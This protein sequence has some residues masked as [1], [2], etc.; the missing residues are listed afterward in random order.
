MIWRQILLLYIGVAGAAGLVWVAPELARGWYP[1]GRVIGVT[2]LFTLGWLTL[3]IWGA[4]YQFLPVALERRIRWPWL[5]HGTYGLF[6]PGLALF[7]VG[8]AFGRAGVMLAG[9]AALVVAVVGFC[10]NLWATLA[11][12][13]KRDLTWWCLLAAG[14]FLLLTL[15]VGMASAGSLRWG[16]LG[17]GRWAALGVH[18][19]V[20]LAG[21]VL[22][23]V[24]G[25]GHR[26]LP[27]FLLSHGAPEV[28]GRAAAVLVAGGTVALVALHHA[29]PVLSRWLP[30][31]LIGAGLL[32]FLVQAR[33]YY[34]HRVR[35][36]LDPGLR[37]AALALGVLGVGVALGGAAFSTAPAPARLLTAYGAALVL[38]LSLFV[39]AHYYKIV[40]FLVWFHRYGPLVQERDVPTVSGLYSARWATAAGVLL[41]LGVGVLLAGIVAGSSPVAQVGG[42]VTAAGAVIEST[43][44]GRLAW[45]RP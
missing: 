20:A 36:G 10:V 29:G 14:V 38:G 1:S 40:P 13:P 12:S 23:V 37:L 4:L 2:H 5:A 11:A 6:V 27:M 30:A 8:L 26:L 33:A 16:Y 43:Q 22:M 45:K 18:M 9:V 31:M 7:V 32:A 28:W 42:A 3:S 44:M 17:V 19:H 24:I 21:W 41:S 39:A 34:A 25:V 15:L 35:P